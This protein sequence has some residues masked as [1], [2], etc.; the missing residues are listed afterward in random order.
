MFFKINLNK[1]NNIHFENLKHDSLGIACEAISKQ[2][3]NV[4]SVKLFS[5]A[6]SN[7]IIEEKVKN[8]QEIT[9]KVL[10]TSKQAS[11]KIYNSYKN[12]KF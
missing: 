5:I 10:V 9:R 12:L 1:L 8:M 11:T 7:E 2:D 6:K 3:T 4:Y